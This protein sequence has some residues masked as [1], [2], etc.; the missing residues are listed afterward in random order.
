M[1]AIQ[2][3]AL[4]V[5]TEVVGRAVL[6]APLPSHFRA[7]AP[8]REV[9]LYA[10]LTQWQMVAAAQAAQTDQAEIKP[11]LTLVKPKNESALVTQKGGHANLDLG[12]N[13]K[14]AKTGPSKPSH[15]QPLAYSLKVIKG[16]L[17]VK[18]P[19]F[20]PALLRQIIGK[21]CKKGQKNTSKK[22]KNDANY[23]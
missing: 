13:H 20:L 10:S 21:S 19:N 18:I 2:S 17:R 15:F 5:Q 6:C 22:R 9:R 1:I 11:N 14:I 8:W 12:S 23:D 3:S 4:A 16:N 7:L